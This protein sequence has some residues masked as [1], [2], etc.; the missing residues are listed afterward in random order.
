MWVD[1]IY[2]V[3]C[4]S[5]H[6]Q[7][8][9]AALREYHGKWIEKGATTW[10]ELWDAD[11]ASHA[12][13]YGAVVNWVL[14]SYIL[15]IRPIKP[16]FTEVIFDPR[17]GDLTWAKGIVPTPLGDIRVSWTKNQAGRIMAD[18]HAPRGINVFKSA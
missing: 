17:P 9:L 10:S 13:T 1:K 12:Q 5:G 14:T 11:A 16:G 8:V 2:G 6:D 3:L 4:E 7:E 18:I 15:G